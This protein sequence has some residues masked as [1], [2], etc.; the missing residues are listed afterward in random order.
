MDGG[1]TNLAIPVLTKAL[2]EIICNVFGS[3]TAVTFVELVK[4]PLRVVMPEVD[5]STDPAQPTFVV[6]VAELI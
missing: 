3:F 1:S 5:K 2:F 6:E 4:V